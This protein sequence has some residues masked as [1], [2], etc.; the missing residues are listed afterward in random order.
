MIKVFI[1]GG[2]GWAGSELSKAVFKRQDMQLTGVLS[3]SHKGKDLGE[4]LNL[5][6]INIPIF[7]DIDNALN[8]VDF[9]VLIDYTKPDIAKRNVLS[10]LKKSKKVI[11]GTSGLTAD[12]YDE[13][14]KIANEYNTSVLAVGNFAITV[15]LLQKF[16]E[17][18]ASYI[19]N[20]ELIDYAHEDKVDAPSGTA[21]ELA[22]RLSLIQKPTIHIPEDKLVGEKESRGA[23]L[24]GVRVHSVRLPGYVIAIEAIFGLKDEKL[25]IRH[26]SGTSAEPYVKGAL[27]AIEKIGTFKG[28]KRG[29]DAVMDFNTKN[30]ND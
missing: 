19:P 11:I 23:N 6:A 5:G 12:D 13:I 10:A 26:D 8:E 14:E 30:I 3:R 21:R 20:F 22:H 15:V 16:A 7:D 28:L 29:L 4:I 18:A 1:A 2:T 17:I 25:T 24:D 9:D 27:L